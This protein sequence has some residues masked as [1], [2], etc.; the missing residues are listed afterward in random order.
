M[1]HMAIVGIRHNDPNWTLGDLQRA[2]FDRQ[3]HRQGDAGQCG[4]N[5]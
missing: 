4:V 2:A 3:A 5:Q 1:G